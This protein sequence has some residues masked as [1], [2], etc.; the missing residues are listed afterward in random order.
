MYESNE[1]KIEWKPILKRGGIFI[2]ILIIVILIISLVSRCSK[3]DNPNPDNKETPTTLSS[4]LDVF[5]EALLKYLTVDTLPKEI[6]SSKTIRIKLLE[7]KKLLSSLV[8]SENNSCMSNDS[9]AEVT[10]FEN[11]YAVNISLTCGSKKEN[12]LIYVGCFKECNGGICKGTQDSNEGVCYEQSENQSSSNNT[13]STN[14]SSNTST[15]SNNTKPNTTTKPS[16]KPSTPSKPSGGNN[17]TTK[18]EV[19]YE[20]QR[21]STNYSCSNGTLVGNKC[22]T[23]KTSRLTQELKK[24]DVRSKSS[25]LQN[26]NLSYMIYDYVGYA[27]G[28]YRYI[29]YY[30]ENQAYT[31]DLSN[32][33]CYYDKVEK[34]ENPA[35]ENTSCEYTWSKST[36]LE[37]WVKT[38]RTQ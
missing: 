31:V 7:D 30:C 35:K 25:N 21:C 5:E 20:Y 36:D 28:Y 32:H 34:V 6:N 17:T 12:R 10:R 38:G 23:E 22:V 18:P 24:R 13:Q 15:P 27:D 33:K 26:K 8:D 9:F 19:L 11:N 37:G 16:T 14:A 1:H 29:E 2:G 3:N 4:Q